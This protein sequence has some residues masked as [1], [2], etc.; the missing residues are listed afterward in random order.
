MLILSVRDIDG[1]RK[2]YIMSKI[3]L[4]ALSLLTL[5]VTTAMVSAKI[6][7]TDLPLPGNTLADKSMQSKMLFPVD[8]YAYRIAAPGCYNFSITDTK[9]SKAKANGQ[10]EE[11]W[12]IKACERTGYIPVIFTE[13]ASGVNY[14]FDPMGVRVS[15]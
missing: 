5:S 10:W 8:A 4:M 2:G 6:T 14:A 9:V 15:K 12:T 13:D 11:I 1:K 7:N 3:K